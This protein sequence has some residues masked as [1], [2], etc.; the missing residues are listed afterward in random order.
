MPRLRSFAPESGLRR[1]KSAACNFTLRLTGSRI[2]SQVVSGQSERVNPNTTTERSG[3]VDQ[4]RY[5]SSDE[6]ERARLAALR[7]YCVLDT[8]HEARFDDLTSLAASICETPVSLISFVDANRLFFKSAH[9]LD[10]REVLHPDFFCS[11]AIRQSELFVV[12]DAFSDPRFARHPMVVDPPGARF[13]AGAPLVTPQGHALGTLSVTDFVAR[14]LQA[15]Q[16]EILRIL[17][18]QVMTQL[19]L[20]LQ[21]MRDPLTGLYNR[22]PLKETLRREILRAPHRLGRGCYGGRHRPFQARERHAGPRSGR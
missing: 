11:H 19:E 8:G 7:S 15:R 22:R 18:R 14:Q 3:A 5:L 13:Y 16:A 2:N 12:P 9:G 17:A 10:A 21:A 1:I 6:Q 4:K 20:T